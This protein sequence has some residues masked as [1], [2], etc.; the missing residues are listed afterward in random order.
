MLTLSRQNRDI[1]EVFSPG[2]STSAFVDA[3]ADVF[4]GVSTIV[5]LDQQDFDDS[6]SSSS[7]PC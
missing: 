3:L 2:F 1:A 5:Y 4:N 6:H 7:G